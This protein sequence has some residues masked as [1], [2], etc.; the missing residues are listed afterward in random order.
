MGLVETDV[1]PTRH[2]DG[3]ASRRNRNARL[4]FACVFAVRE[5]TAAWQDA[6]A[7]FGG[8]PTKRNLE[9]TGA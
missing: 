6:I 5:A 2:R 3:L 4:L 8:M 1:Q 9:R 7:T